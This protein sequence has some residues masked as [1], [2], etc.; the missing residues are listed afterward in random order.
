MQGF[1]YKDIIN[2]FKSYLDN[3]L[4]ETVYFEAM[5]LKKELD[6][7]H[8]LSYYKDIIEKER[9][10]MNDVLNAEQT[11]VFANQLKSL[12]KIRH[13]HHYAAE[14]IAGLGDGSDFYH[15]INSI[16]TFCSFYYI[17]SG[18]SFF[19]ELNRESES[20]PVS[21]R[22]PYWSFDLLYSPQP[23]DLLYQLL[24]SLASNTQLKDLYFNFIRFYFSVDNIKE[25]LS[26][27]IN[28]KDTNFI[29]FIVAILYIYFIKDEHEE[30]DGE[31]RLIKKVMQVTEHV[32]PNEIESQFG[33]ID[34]IQSRLV[35]IAKH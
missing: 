21:V 6:K 12:N 19:K 9:F 32:M 8:Q 13:Y 15:R 16:Q 30:L 1:I 28:K 11:K 25:L 7:D 34:T 10:S 18:K 33:V 23:F 5:R 3:N 17:D 35:L 22:I 26:R 29:A 24:Q 27:P 31:F 14:N 20:L 4:S 2:E